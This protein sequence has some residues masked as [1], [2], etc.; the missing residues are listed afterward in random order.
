MGNLSN[1]DAYSGIVKGLSGGSDFPVDI[2]NPQDGQ[3]LRYNA[4]SESWENVDNF[5]RIINKSYEEDYVATAEDA[6]YYID[7]EENDVVE[8]GSY[9]VETLD[10][11]CGEINENVVYKLKWLN[12]GDIYCTSN[13]YSIITTT[14]DNIYYVTI[15]Y[16]NPGTISTSILELSPIKSNSL[17]LKIF[18]P[19][20]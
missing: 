12:V 18:T 19:R 10:I 15:F 6:L 20:K 13:I 17:P 1:P 16:F 11:S 9:N 7:D 8:G 2:N 3:I 14:E 5:V 4:E